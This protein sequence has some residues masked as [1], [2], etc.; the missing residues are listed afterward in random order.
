MRVLT[1]SLEW[2]HF[3]WHGYLFDDDFPDPSNRGPGVLPHA[4]ISEEERLRAADEI[5]RRPRI[6]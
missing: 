5:R 2:F 6:G 4:E 3:R 1:K